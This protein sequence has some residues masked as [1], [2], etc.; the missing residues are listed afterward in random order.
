MFFNFYNF[1]R[2]KKN[3][4][5]ERNRSAE[6]SLG[7]PG[8]D[9]RE[10]IL[11]NN[12]PFAKENYYDMSLIHCNLALAYFH[13]KNPIEGTCHCN[14][15]FE[16]VWYYLEEEKYPRKDQLKLFVNEL[17]KIDFLNLDIKEKLGCLE[18]KIEYLNFIVGYFF[19]L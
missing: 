10:S 11:K 1:L 13:D 4:A 8:L 14:K 3:Q 9:I 17:K 12:L 19:N 5:A 15:Y 2:N 16:K 6:H 18:R 7:N